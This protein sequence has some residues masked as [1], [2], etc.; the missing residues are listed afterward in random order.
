MVWKGA[1]G[2]VI[3]SQLRQ[4]NFSRTVCT[5]FHCRGTTSSVSVTS[6]PSLAELAAAARAGGGRRDHHAFAWQV[7]GKRCPHRLLAGEA[8][9]DGVVL[10]RLGGGGERV[11]GRACLQLLEL[12][13]ELIEQLAAALGR[14]PE[15]LASQFGD[16]QLQMRDHGL[17]TRGAGFGL[18]AGR[19]LGDQRH[20]EC[21][22]PVGENVGCNRHERDLTIIARHCDDLAQWVS[23][24]VAP[25]PTAC[26]RQ[27]CCGLRQSMPSSM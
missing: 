19:A 7:L 16:D 25:Y 21:V 18:L 2:W 27:V 12:Q 3:F 11:F 8:A 14:W 15:A 23:Q 6:S 1:G 4:V 9:H 13:L 5:T 26:G 22:D 10:A 20:L 24:L 17:G